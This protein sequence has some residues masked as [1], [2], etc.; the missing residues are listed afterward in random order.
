MQRELAASGL[1]PEEILAKTLLLQK[2]KALK[3]D[4]VN[5]SYFKFSLFILTEFIF[6]IS[7]VYEFFAI[8]YS[9]FNMAIT[10]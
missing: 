8:L 5:L 4:V 10:L 6:E 9:I 7:M 1:S 2:V 3:P